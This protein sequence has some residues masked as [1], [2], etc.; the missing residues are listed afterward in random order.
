MDNNK[1]STEEAVIGGGCFWCTESVFQRVKG[2]SSVVS[3]YAG[4]ASKNPTYDEVCS[5]KS[6]HAEV[7]QITFDPKEVSFEEL[8]Q[9]FFR[10]HDPTTLNQQG[11]DVGTQYRSV[12]LYNNDK[13]KETAEKVKEEVNKAKVYSDPIVTEIAPLATFYS[14]EDSHQN[15]YNENTSHGYCNYVIKPKLDKFYKLFKSRVKQA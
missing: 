9:I 11:N 2:V 13:Q 5:G 1:E 6:G 14:A 8:L 4:G 12:I 15:F 10:V 7:I 3:G